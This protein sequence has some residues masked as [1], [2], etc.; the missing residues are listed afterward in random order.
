MRRACSS[1]AMTGPGPRNFPERIRIMHSH[2][3]CRDEHAIVARPI[4]FRTLEVP[5][6][7]RYR[8]TLGACFRVPPHHRSTGWMDLL[9]GAETNHAT[10][11]T[12]E[13]KLIHLRPENEMF[14]SV[15][16]KFEPRVTGPSAVVH[17]YL[18]PDGGLH[19]E[20]PRFGME[21]F[22]DGKSGLEVNGK[23]RGS[24]ILC[25]DH[26]GYEL[27][28]V[29]QLRDPVTLPEC[30]RY[31]VLRPIN[32]ADPT[33]VIVSRGKVVVRDGDKPLVGIGTAREQQP[34]VWIKCPS[35]TRRPPSWTYTATTCTRGGKEL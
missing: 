7:I 2:W 33:R 8:D 24:G 26:R 5:F 9:V 32:D 16:A 17:T 15:L 30:S 6:V 28:I 27:D 4:N 29:Q 19:I 14:L 20:L 35:E 34:L 13:G 3:L 12:E 23:R 18:Q 25:L 31:L 10:A 11:T 1:S 21:F 22:I